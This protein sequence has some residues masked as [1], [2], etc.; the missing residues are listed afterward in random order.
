MLERNV[1]EMA[2]VVCSAGE[3]D[4]RRQMGHQSLG[5]REAWPDQEAPA[6]K[7]KT[8]SSTR[9]REKQETMAT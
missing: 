8:G 2:V 9:R 1:C 7:S 3:G 4:A 6:V 5:L